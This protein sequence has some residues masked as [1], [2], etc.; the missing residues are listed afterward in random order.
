MTTR[1]FLLDNLKLESELVPEQGERNT[2]IAGR[3]NPRFCTE[4]TE[5]RAALILKATYYK[6]MN[7]DRIPK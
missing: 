4:G 2:R 6:Q 1:S 7:E 3:S 5:V